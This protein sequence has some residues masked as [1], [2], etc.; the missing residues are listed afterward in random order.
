MSDEFPTD[1]P[2]SPPSEPAPPPAPDTSEI[3]NER[4]HTALSQL[5]K[6]ESVEAYAH[7]RGSSRCY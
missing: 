3:I 6:D 7:E 1:I 4:R 5:A 2:A